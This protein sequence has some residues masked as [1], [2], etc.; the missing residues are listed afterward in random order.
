[1]A[2]DPELQ[3]ALVAVVTA[4]PWLARVCATEPLALDGLTGLEGPVGPTAS[5]LPTI[6]SLEPFERVRRTR[7][8]GVLRIAAR[9]LLGLDDL[10]A[11]GAALSSLARLVLVEALELAGAPSAGLAVVGL[12]KLGANELNYASD[13][14]L[15]LVSP[16]PAAEP[17]DPRPFLELARHGW[18]ID[19]DLRP[20]GRSGPVLR[21]LASYQAY[22]ARWAETWE[23]QALLKA[24]PV[25]GDR[26]LGTRFA[27]AAAEQIW[28]RPF[29]ADDLRQVRYL[30][31][32]AE[33]EVQRRHRAEREVKRGPGG[34][35]DI[36]FSVQLLQMVHGRDDD[37]VRAPDTLGALDALAA[38]GYVAPEDADALAHAYRF[39]RIVEHRLQMYEGQ[40]VHSLPQTPER[41]RHLAA[42]M[43]YRPDGGHSSVHQ[44]DEDL[45]RHRAAVRAIHERLFFRPLLEVFTGGPSRRSPA[46]SEEAVAQRLAAFGFADATRTAQAVTEL[47]RGFS[48]MSQLMQRMLPVLLDWLSTSADPDQGLL[49]LRVLA[50]GAQSR[51][52]LTAICRESPVAARQLCQLLGTG[53]RLARDL[54]RH[55]D[56]LAGLASGQ[57]PAARAVE[58]LRAQ[59]VRSLSWRSGKG[60]TEL[61][62]RQFAQAERLRIAARDVLGLDDIGQVGEDLSDLA[63]AVIDA[64]LG[65]VAPDVPF[66]VIGMG[67]LGGREIGYGSDVDLLLVWDAPEDGTSSGAEP[68]ELAGLALIRLIGGSSPATGAYQVDLKLRPEGRHGPAARSLD[69]YAAYLERWAAPWEKQALLRSRVVA[70]DPDVGARFEALVGRFV[71]DQALSPTDLV[72]I[73]RSKARIEK[74]RVP[75]GEDPKYHLKLGPGSMSDVEWTVQL[76]QLRHRIEGNGTVETLDRLAAER[77][78]GRSDAAELRDSYVFCARA[79]NRLSLIRDLP[80]ESLPPPGPVLSTLARSLGYSPSGLRNEYARVTRRARRVMERLFYDA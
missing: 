44:M 37:T 31:A 69:A 55:P 22:W 76:L 30:K 54:Q 10:E 77:I 61:G 80:G 56:A 20:E 63:D 18:R 46:L 28:R 27:G 72:E 36:E 75:A 43:G 51:D 39:L 14:D 19:L 70:G 4:S 2:N 65:Q 45:R 57:F 3:R 25:A 53:P 6:T 29:G 8:L 5:S 7:D 62:L 13:I 32:R 59:A 58:D 38:G 26:E 49:G 1:M 40:P 42:T 9:D 79:R 17:V 73:R 15:V 74:E 35:R 71:R 52:R 12:G 60:A 34:I 66:T 24:R 47:T 23:F 68:A 67:R 64:A 21:T 48:R 50:E 11:V 41:R 33:L 16:D 78:V